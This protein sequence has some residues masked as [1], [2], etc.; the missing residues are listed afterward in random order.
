LNPSQT[1]FLLQS[2]LSLPKS[3]SFTLSTTKKIGARKI[4]ISGVIIFNIDN[5]VDFQECSTRDETHLYKYVCR[6]KRT[7]FMFCDFSSEKHPFIFASNN[8]QPS[9]P[10]NISLSDFSTAT[11]STAI[12]Q[13]QIYGGFHLRNANSKIPLFSKPVVRASKF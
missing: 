7:K 13:S 2:R 9:E 10:L 11:L 4:D 8:Q 5:G 3:S 6:A 1:K 12:S